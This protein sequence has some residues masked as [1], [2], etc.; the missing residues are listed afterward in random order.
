MPILNY[1]TSIEATKS[2]SEIEQLLS[3]S[4]ATKIQKD[5]DN[6]GR[7]TCIA[8]KIMT[9][10]GELLFRLPMNLRAVHQTLKNQAGEYK[11]T[12]YGQQRKIPLS[13]ATEEQA[14]QAKQEEQDDL[15][16]YNSTTGV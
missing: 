7:V 11:R 15:S 4:G 8:F 2:I 12:K 13:K 6:Q 1:T 3:Q 16:I 5:Y 9:E 10:K 14:E